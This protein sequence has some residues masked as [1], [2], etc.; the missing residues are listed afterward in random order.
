MA[1][2]TL[3]QRRSTPYT[4]PATSTLPLPTTAT[5]ATVPLRPDGRGFPTTSLPPSTS[6][7]SSSSSSPSPPSSLP[8]YTWEQVASHNTLDSCWVSYHSSV[9][10]VTP[11]LDRHPGGRDILLLAAGRDLTDLLPSYHPFTSTPHTILTKHLIGHLSTSEFPQYQPDSG[12]YHDLRRQVHQYFLDTGLDSKAATPGLTRLAGMAVVGGLAFAAMLWGGGG[13]PLGVR[14][15]CAVVF[16]VCQAL[17]LLHCMHDASHMAIGRSASV[18]WWVGRLC[19]DWFAGASIN[20]WHHQHVL[21]HHVY[22]NVMGVDPDLPASKVGDIRRIC[23]QQQ[24]GWVYGF[25]HVYLTV[26]YGLLALKFRLQDLTDTWWKRENGMIRVNPANL[27]DQL[28]L[29][30]S[31]A[32]WVVWRFVLPLAYAGLHSWTEFLALSL[33]AEL[34]TGWYLTF[35]FQVSHVSPPA[36]FPD[37]DKAAFDCEWAPSQLQT[38]VDYAHGDGLAAFLCGALNYQSVH[39]L[40]PCVSQYHYPALAPIVQRVAKKWGVRYNYVGSFWQ[41]FM[42]H[43]QHLQDMG[44]E[45]LHH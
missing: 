17:P 43:L 16:G 34:V 8:S 38:T 2:Q 42:L 23:R 32:C 11:W 29:M 21:G 19:M 7:S 27:T 14:L 44:V 26:L 33:V 18:W 24:W 28:A 15:M 9:Y 45:G 20:S 3:T 40:F 10:D 4:S 1:T 6:S 5:K 22:T 39:H 37:G 13:L 30:T 25:Q 31:K 41:A 36:D 12:F 35:N